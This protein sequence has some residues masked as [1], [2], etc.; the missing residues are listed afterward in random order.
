VEGGAGGGG[1]Y[2]ACRREWN[3]NTRVCAHTRAHYLEVLARLEWHGHDAWL[4][5]CAIASRLCTHAHTHT[6]THT[7]A[8]THRHIH[9]NAH[10]PHTH[11]PHTD[12][13]TQTHTDTH[14]HI[15]E[16]APISRHPRQLPP[17]SSP[18]R[19]LV[20]RPTAPI[21]Q[22]KVLTKPHAGKGEA[23]SV[24]HHR[25]AASPAPRSDAGGGPNR[26]RSGVGDGTL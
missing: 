20:T 22:L 17:N 4:H 12:I 26:L 11:I 10:T 7:S 2:H 3:I 25:G 21:N 5:V 18:S 24:H 16:R 14:T 19:L 8:H 9:T 6:H 15:Y 13:H 1:G 23:T